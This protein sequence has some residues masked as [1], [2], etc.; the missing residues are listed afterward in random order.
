MNIVNKS[1]VSI[2]E[3]R[4]KLNG[5]AGQVAEQTSSDSGKSFDRVLLDKADQIKFSR[6]AAKRLETRNIS[7]SD[8]QKAR[9]ENAAEQAMEKGMTESLVMVDDLAFILNVRNRTIVTAVNDTANAVFT[10]IDGA[11]IN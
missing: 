6:H 4:S 7:I 11:I 5:G 8:E 10:N 9:L 3:I 1:F 2:D